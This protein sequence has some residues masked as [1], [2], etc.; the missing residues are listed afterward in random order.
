MA[1]KTLEEKKI[2]RIAEEKIV[3]TRNLVP[4]GKRANLKE[5]INKIRGNDKVNKD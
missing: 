4:Y 5:C 2:E 1:K 3:S